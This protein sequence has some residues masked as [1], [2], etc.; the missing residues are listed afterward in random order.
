MLGL[1]LHLV[2]HELV[3]SEDIVLGPLE[4]QRGI[5][6]PLVFRFSVLLVL[7]MLVVDLELGLVLEEGFVIEVVVIVMGEAMVQPLGLVEQ[8]LVIE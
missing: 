5:T 6:G 8:P 4:L 2:L 7:L 1:L 3:H